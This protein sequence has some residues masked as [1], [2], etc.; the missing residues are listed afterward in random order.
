MES[1]KLNTILIIACIAITGYN[2]VLLTSGSSSST[3]TSAVSS[4]TSGVPTPPMNMEQQNAV[5]A[6]PNR[7]LTSMAFAQELH[8]FG[9]IKQETTNKYVFEFTNTGVEPLVIENAT[10]SCGCTVPNYP[11]EPIMPGQKGQIEVEYK[12]GQQEGPQQKTVTVTANTEPRQTLLKIKA[13]VTK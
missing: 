6:D 7:P 3:N 2:T 10:G 5:P 12:P 13:N 8:D 1:Q 11:K 9:D 4:T